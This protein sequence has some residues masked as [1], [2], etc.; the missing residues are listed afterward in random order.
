[1]REHSLSLDCSDDNKRSLSF[2]YD[3]DD[4]KHLWVKAFKLCD[5]EPDVLITVVLDE[6]SAEAAL[7]FIQ[8]FLLNLSRA[9]RK[10][11]YGDLV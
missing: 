7:M 2:D 9:K 8:S 3:S 1:M 4:K 5:P 11:K 6:E 10:E